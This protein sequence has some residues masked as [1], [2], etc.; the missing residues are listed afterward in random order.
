[1]TKTIQ[2]GNFTI[3]IHRPDQVSEAVEREVK[4]AIEAMHEYI[5]G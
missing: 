2:H 3:T 1:M 4:A 5:K